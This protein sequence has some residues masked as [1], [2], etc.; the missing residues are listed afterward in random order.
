MEDLSISTNGA[1]SSMLYGCIA[2]EINFVTA[3]IHCFLSVVS[4]RGVKLQN[5]LLP[6]ASWH[7]TYSAKSELAALSAE[8]GA[9]MTTDISII[10]WMAVTVY[11]H[12]YGQSSFL[13]CLFWKTLDICISDKLPGFQSLNFLLQWVAGQNNSAT[14]FCILFF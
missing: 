6:F 4:V 9:F 8:L 12:G 7:F 13:R 2:V 10:S 14:D 11:V 3:A 5:S 1:H